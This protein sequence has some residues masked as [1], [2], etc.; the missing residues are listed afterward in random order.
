MNTRSWSL[1]SLLMLIAGLIVGMLAGAY[2]LY[3]WIPW[4]WIVRDVSPSYL[5]QNGITPQ[6]RDIYVS[7]VA[8]RY[9]LIANVSGRQA[10]ALKAA[11]DLLGVTT[12]DSTPAEAVAIVQ[13]TFEVVKKE[14]DKDGN[15]G[16]FIKSDENALQSLT[17]ALQAAQNTPVVIKSGGI[18]QNNILWT[19]LIGALA[20][21]ALLLLGLLIYYLLMRRRPQEEG[22]FAQGAINEPSSSQYSQPPFDDIR[23][24]Q[25]TYIP[26]QPAQP[27]VQQN[28]A[29]P[30]APHVIAPSYIEE[31][32]A[33]TLSG[34]IGKL[35]S[36]LRTLDQITFV[37][38]DENFDASVDI[39]G[40]GNTLVG[41]CAVT[42]IESNGSVK[43][44]EV[45]ALQL[46]LY[47]K[48]AI[49]SKSAVLVTPQC[50]NDPV[51]RQKL[52]G[53]G[54]LFSAQN[55]QHIEINNATLRAIAEISNLEVIE[56]DAHRGYFK[57]ATVT[58]HVQPQK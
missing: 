26:V 44:A 38:G 57:K 4:Q 39:V 17:A 24:P 15:A 41:T 29:V 54:D 35:D 36:A 14:N 53:K 7:N 19:R 50:M 32:R 46:S 58:F 10:E 25:E 3:A 20:L 11:Q 23:D 12:G 33:D 16:W 30:S 49:R 9:Q 48:N 1:N 28:V 2:I 18:A 6:Y 8:N 34:N 13:K 52:I 21:L 37:H 56:Q 51:I 42:A 22:D 27:I 45:H 5:A 40:A 55:G 47:D 43:P 31:T